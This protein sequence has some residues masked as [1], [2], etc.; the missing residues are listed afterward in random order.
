MIAVKHY[1]VFDSDKDVLRIIPDGHRAVI[2]SADDNRV[3]IYGIPKPTDCRRGKRAIENLFTGAR[4][5]HKE[6]RIIPE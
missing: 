5:I 1:Q 4:L 3:K 6:V 2:V